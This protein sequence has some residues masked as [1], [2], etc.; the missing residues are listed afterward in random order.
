M[1]LD[2]WLWAIR[3]YKTRTLAADAIKGGHVKIAAGPTK[4]AHEVRPGEV[5]A[6]RV[7]QLTRTIRVLAAPPSRVAAKLVAQF[8]EDLTPPEEYAR[9][10]DANLLPPGFRAKGA[11]RPTKQDRR[12]IDE[13]FGL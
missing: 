3:I 12:A 4:P 13:Q 10:R 5:I 6:A 7:G 9:R 2:Q 11:G 1:R 8:A